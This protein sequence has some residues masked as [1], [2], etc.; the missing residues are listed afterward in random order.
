MDIF[1]YKYNSSR[2]ELLKWIG[3][4]TMVVDHLGFI[5]FYENYIM[6]GVGRIAFPIFAFLLVHN[7][8][9]FTRC[10]KCMLLRLLLF[11]FISQPIYWYFFP[12]Y[13]NILFTLFLGLFTIYIFE[14]VSSS[15][16]KY[17]I[18]LHFIFLLFLPL[19]TLLSYS[20]LGYLFI[21]VTWASF[22]FRYINIFWV[23]LLFFLNPLYVEYVFGILLF[24]FVFLLSKY[25][26]VTPPRLAGNIFYI[27]Y[28]LHLLLFFFIDI[29]I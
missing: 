17:V 3:I 19:S 25:I 18:I 15:K 12:A 1:F 2:I 22:H 28:P 26:R 11:A 7:Y 9:F 27:F 16:Y 5:F 21:L 29:L 8:L 10:K 23:I 4:F 6:R 20:A 13:L 24:L 14:T